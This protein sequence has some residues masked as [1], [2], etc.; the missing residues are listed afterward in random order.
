MNE[1][2]KNITGLSAEIDNQT[3]TPEPN[4]VA[5]QSS[6][7]PTPISE[8]AVRGEN[9]KGGKGKTSKVIKGPKGKTSKVTKGPKGFDYF[10]KLTNEVETKMESFKLWKA[11]SSKMSKIVKNPDLVTIDTELQSVPSLPN[12]QSS[13]ISQETQNVAP[14]K[15]MQPNLHPTQPSPT[16][17]ENIPI[18]EPQL[19]SY[20]DCFSPSV[21]PITT[22]IQPVA[23]PSVQSHNLHPALAETSSS[24]VPPLPVADRELRN[25]AK[26]K[27]KRK[28]RLRCEDQECVPCSVLENCNCCHF[29][30][31]RSKL[32]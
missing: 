24:S 26:K 12:F 32:R 18:P 14:S 17:Y 3:N 8:E 10:K 25:Q 28:S 30:L 20:I 16:N 22:T 9:S 29:C 2:S 13:N 21:H 7:L 1:I 4:N 31:N 27:Q 11:S 23:S 15:S 6:V 19:S 5:V